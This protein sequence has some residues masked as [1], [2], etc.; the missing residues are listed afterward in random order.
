MRS[1]IFKNFDLV[2]LPT[3]GMILFLTVFVGMFLWT[4]RK[5]S[6]KYYEEIQQLPISEE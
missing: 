4:F 1:Q 2:L 6:K 5:G 3:W